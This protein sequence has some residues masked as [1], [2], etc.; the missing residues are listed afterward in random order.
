MGRA[1]FDRLQETS[2]NFKGTEELRSG[3][4]GLEHLAQTCLTRYSERNT[5]VTGSRFG[6][7][8]LPVLSRS[9]TKS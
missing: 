6:F 7:D 4:E 8:Q 1:P 2:R 3:L 5:S 9:G